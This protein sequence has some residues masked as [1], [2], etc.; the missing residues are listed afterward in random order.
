[1]PPCPLF[2][3]KIMGLTVGYFHAKIKVEIYE[4]EEV[5]LWLLKSSL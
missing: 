4:Q 3:R 1:M 5:Y 2:R